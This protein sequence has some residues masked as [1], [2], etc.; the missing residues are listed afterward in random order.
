MNEVRELMVQRSD[1]PRLDKFLAE[2]IEEF[3]RAQLQNLIKAG[4][5]FLNG[6]KELKGK[7]ALQNGDHIRIVLPSL[8]P[9]T[10]QPEEINLD[11][12]FE[13]DDIL[14]VN[15]PAGMVVHPA[16][17]HDSG[18]L[19]HAALHHLPELARGSSDFRPGVVH[20]LDK[21]TSGLIILAKNDASY[22]FL[23][24]QFKNRRVRKTYLAIVHGFPP[25]PLGRVEAPVGRDAVQRK[26][27][28]IVPIIKGREA[29]TEYK[30]IEKFSAHSLIE[31]YPLTG[32]THQIRLH[33]AFLGCPVL[34]DRLYGPRER[35][36][37]V[38]RQMLHAF[39]LEITLPGIKTTR[40]FEAPLPEDM[41]LILETFRQ[42]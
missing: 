5:V 20:R 36:F 7:T 14:V 26:K 28:A 38:K 25:T 40:C 9:E 21:E 41:K 18:T 12:I 42:V 22:H 4:E 33:L 34:G 39:R 37:P 17:G 10:L 15:K 30:M 29:V 35:N 13:N 24:N 32:R 2:E 11:I 27:M 3:S 6:K 31:A 8:K 16:Q 23:Q 19:V 1:Q